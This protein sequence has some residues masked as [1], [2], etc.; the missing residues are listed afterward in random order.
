M[1]RVTFT[2]ADRIRTSI[3]YRALS[4]NGNRYYNDYF[5]IISQANQASR[6]RLGITVSKKVG[7]AV[8]RNR[9]KRII[10]EHFRLNRRILPDRLDINIIARPSSGRIRAAAI[11]D[12]LER[13]FKA[14]TAKTR[15]AGR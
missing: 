3:E 10:R 1:T 8:T 6:S 5:V 7:N 14:I 9:I 12:H 2:K 11:R 15:I 4:K 13:C